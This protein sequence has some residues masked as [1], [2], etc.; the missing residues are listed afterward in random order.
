[1]ALDI[2][3]MAKWPEKQ[4]TGPDRRKAPFSS[5][6]TNTIELLASELDKLSARTVTLHT[7]HSPHDV[8][9]DGKLRGD[10]TNPKHPGVVLTFEKFEGWSEE[11]QQSKYVEM[12]FPCDTFIY[13]K[14]NVRAI[15]LALEALRKIDRYGVRSGMQ[16]AGFKA[17][18]PGDFTVDMTPELAADFIAKAAG[19]GNVPAIATSIIQ[20][21]VF[22]E[23]VYRTAAKALHPDKSGNADEF[24]KLES[25]WRLVKEVQKQSAAAGG[26]A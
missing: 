15:A 2:Q 24:K 10:S 6:W 12:R 18:P 19:M 1:M 5:P 7:M 3:P 8:R 4:E 17:L 25:A 13:W 22:G 11:E 16:Y 21:V 14:D 20:N 23:S 9:L 26:E